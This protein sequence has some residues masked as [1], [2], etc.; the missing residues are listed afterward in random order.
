MRENCALKN[1]HDVHRFA[2]CAPAKA[3]M[4]LLSSA[5]GVAIAGGVVTAVIACVMHRNETIRLQ[6]QQQWQRLRSRSSAGSRCMRVFAVTA[7]IIYALIRVFS[8]MTAPVASGGSGSGSG[9]GGVPTEGGGVGTSIDDVMRY[10]DM[11]EP[12]F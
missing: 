1:V 9:S 6:E 7:C 8:P 12:D 10:I 11:S 5:L 3:I 2:R 4:K